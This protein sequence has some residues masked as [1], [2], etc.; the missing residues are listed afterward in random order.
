MTHHSCSGQRYILWQ[1]CMFL[2]NEYTEHDMR[3]WDCT[4]LTT[5]IY[6]ISPL[7]HLLLLQAFLSMLHLLLLYSFVSLPCTTPSAYFG[8]SDFE[9]SCPSL[10]STPSN[11]L[12][13]PAICV[14]WQLC[15]AQCWHIFKMGTAKGLTDVNTCSFLTWNLLLLHGTCYSS[16]FKSCM[17][18]WKELMICLCTSPDSFE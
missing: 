14:P 12:T 10:G 5:S 17:V 3:L 15:G 7:G 11:Q 13:W 16:L 18:K 2:A 8:L 9:A 6:S 4:L 1:L